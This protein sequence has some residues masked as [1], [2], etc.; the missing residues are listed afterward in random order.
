MLAS[1]GREADSA[2]PI[3]MTAGKINDDLA[4]KIL[5]LQSIVLELQDAA[6][7]APTSPVFTNRRFALQ[8][9]A[10][11][12]Q[13]HAVHLRDLV[14]P[15]RSVLRPERF[16]QA[17]I[18]AAADD[19]F[20][21]ANKL[22]RRALELRAEYPEAHKA[23]SDVLRKQEAIELRALHLNRLPIQQSKRK[24]SIALIFGSFGSGGLRPPLYLTSLPVSVDLVMD[25]LA[26]RLARSHNVIAYCAREGSQ[27]KIEQYGGVEY[28]R[29]LEFP[30]RRWSNFASWCPQYISEVIA[31]PSLRGCDIV[32]IMNLPEFV[33]FVRARLPKTRIVLHMQCQW[34][35]QLDATMIEPRINA[36]DLVLGCSN[37]IAAGVRRRFPSLAQRCRHIYNG[38]DI[39]LFTR[40]AGV[41]PKPKQLLFIGRLAPEKGVH[42]LLDAFRIVLAHHPDAHLEL[43]GPE[44]VVPLEVLF[45]VRDDPHVHEIEPYFQAGKY[46]EFLRAKVSEFPSGSISFFNKG[47][48]FID[49]VPHYHSASIFAFPSVWEEPFGMPVVEAMASATPV[50][51]TRGG[52]FPEIVEDG[53]S[54]L[55]VERSDVQG[56]A[57]AILQLLSHPNQ[58]DAMAQAALER[59]S[60]M[61]SWDSIA[62][63]LLKEYE[64]LFV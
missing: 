9:A 42:V 34:L 44:A 28:R 38:A 5:D 53:K 51:A 20:E 18:V 64:R 8:S 6:E 24:F 4:Q 23:L 54:G 43:I 39:A 17:G 60:T 3:A 15:L 25:E 19:R 40:P 58:R 61:F 16:Y 10:I 37:F 41:Q 13:E 12:L 2:E 63:N 36:A 35:E 31:D 26:Q 56:L 21:I 57:E 50:V 46:T 32:H 62:E 45:P 59:A 27:Q 29:V 48:K 55:L 49:L 52:A 7:E 22:F 11:A 47:M 14:D 33:P 1:T 30:D